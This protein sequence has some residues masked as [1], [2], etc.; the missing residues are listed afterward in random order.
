LNKLALSISGP[1]VFPYIAAIMI[2]G[3]LVS[4]AMEIPKHGRKLLS[5]NQIT[6]SKAASSFS[7]NIIVIP[8]KWLLWD[9]DSLLIVVK[10]LVFILIRPKDAPLDNSVFKAYSLFESTRESVKQKMA[11]LFLMCLQRL[12]PNSPHELGKSFRRELALRVIKLSENI[13]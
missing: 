11:A 2:L 9:M 1:E 13:R 6:D 3:P 10:T 5:G 7:E 12:L 8:A 4:L